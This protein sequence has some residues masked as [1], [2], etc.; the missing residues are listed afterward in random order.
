MLFEEMRY[1]LGVGFGGE[2]VALFDELP[3]QSEIILDDPVMRNNDAPSA[4][5][6]GMSILFR[7]PSV[8][9]GARMPEPELLRCGLSPEQRPGI[10]PFAGTPPDAALVVF[11]C[12]DSSRVVPAGLQRLWPSHDDRNRIT[13]PD[14]AENPTHLG[15]ITRLTWN[16]CSGVSRN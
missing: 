2:L 1:N 7:W 4:I 6:M 16:C 11:D 5:A 14:V 13:W 3:L 9:G 10:F 15:R 8:G 12:C